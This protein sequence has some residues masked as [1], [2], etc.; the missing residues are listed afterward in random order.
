MGLVQGTGPAGPI[1]LSAA[2]ALQYVSADAGPGPSS[3]FTN[4]SWGGAKVL[5]AVDSAV[6]GPV[7]VRGRQLD[8]PHELRF[9]EP[10]L[11]E[12]LLAP[13]PPI[14][15]HGWRGYP[16]YTRFAGGAVGHGEVRV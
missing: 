13:T 15:P 14:T 3:V 1:G 6:D 16:G 4:K 12:L 11:T 7:L 5:W 8:G 9:N 2:G 10:T